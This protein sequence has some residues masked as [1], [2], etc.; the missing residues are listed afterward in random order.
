MTG[1][2][3][4]PGD[5]VSSLQ[6]ADKNYVDESVA[7]VAGGIGQKVSTVPSATQIVTQP[8]GT[9]LDVNLLNGAEYASQYVNGRGNNGIANA[10][11]GPDCV[12]G[13][14]IVAEQDYTGETLATSTL[15]S[16]T[17]VKDERGGRQV[18]SY[19]N[20]VDVV[21]HALSTA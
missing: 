2:L 14:E 16:Q 4:L 9:Q 17:H 12:N 8:T 13:C 10:S 19:K 20:P 15:N 11:T 5:P 3:V 6:A 21:G 7:T 18:D 1:P